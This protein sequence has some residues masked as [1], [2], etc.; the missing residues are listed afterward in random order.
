MRSPRGFDAST[1]GALRDTIRIRRGCDAGLLVRVIM[2]IVHL[3][4]ARA[5]VFHVDVVP[6][7]DTLK[8]LRHLRLSHLEIDGSGSS[9]S[10]DASA[11]VRPTSPVWIKPCSKRIAFLQRSTGGT[12]S[13]NSGTSDR[14]S[15]KSNLIILRSLLFGSRWSSA[16]SPHAVCSGK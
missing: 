15:T 16:L 10:S 6:C 7:V 9:T 1:A 2:K 11:G 14:P 8:R 5:D 13:C 4:L 3:T 12:W